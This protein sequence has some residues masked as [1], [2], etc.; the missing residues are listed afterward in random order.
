[1]SDAQAMNKLKK[2]LIKE[3]LDQELRPIPTGSPQFMIGMGE[4]KTRPLLYLYDTGCGSV[5]FRDGVPQKELSGCTLKTKG[6]FTVKG[7]GGTAVTVNDEYKVTMGLIDGTRQVL[8]GWTMKKITDTL[9]R[10]SLQAA[11]NEIKSS[12]PE[13][14]EL[15]SL[16][17]E[18]EIGGDVDALIGIL[19]NSIHPVPYSFF[20]KWTHYL[21]V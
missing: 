12:Q 5:L 10:V 8:E 13:N 2:K 11:E 9:P 14:E 4:G 19:Y 21:Q 6:P 15:Q 17:C 3:G 18:P 20:G 16:H 7:V 1:M